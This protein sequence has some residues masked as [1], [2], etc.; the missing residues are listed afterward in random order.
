MANYNKIIMIGNMTRDPQL[1]YLPSNTPVVE[2]GLA[3]NRRWKDQSGQQREETCFVDCRMFGRRA[4]VIS[5]YTSKGSQILIEGRLQLD[6]WQ[7]KDGSP[8]SKHRIF[9]ENFEFLDSRAGGQGQGQGYQGNEGYQ[10]NQQ[11]RPAQAPQRQQP[12]QAPQGYDQPNSYDE[13]QG[14]DQP[15]QEGIDDFGGQPSGDNIPF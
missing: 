7:D 2:F 3:S 13:P 1:S 11:P 8:R 6:R 15:P 5:K 14:Y 10:G 9:V 12:Q 4:E